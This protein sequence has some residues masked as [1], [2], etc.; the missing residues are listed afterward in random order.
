MKRVIRIPVLV[1][2]VASLAWIPASAHAAGTFTL[3]VTKSGNGAGGVT[4]L[5]SA[6]DCGLTCSADMAAG[7]SV[8]LT[9]TADAG[10]V[11]EGWSGSGCSGTGTCTVPMDA[12][13]SVNASFR[14]NIRPDALIRLC[15]AGDTCNGAPPHKYRGNNVYNKTGAGQTY[16]AGME[17]GNDIRFWIMIQNDGALSD[18]IFIKSCAG[19]PSFTI[20][21]INIGA[22]R[23]SIGAGDITKKVKNGTA[24]FDF[25][26]AASQTSVVITL[27]IWERTAIQG[28]RYT[29]P[30]TVWSAS[31][32]TVR[33]R[34]LA[35]MV[36]T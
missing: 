22:W 6:I 11:F 9:A 32:P 14:A 8:D 23:R 18:T 7:V 25:A 33:D 12:A 13:T 35:K 24:S 36:T 15:G 5:P 19:T 10:S 17:E 27:D 16:P 26:P 3:T 30:L 28:L 21:M 1:G 31:D 2:L 34:V 29:C 4:S 20:R